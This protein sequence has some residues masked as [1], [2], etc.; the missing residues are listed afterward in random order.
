MDTLPLRFSSRSSYF[1]TDKIKFPEDI[2]LIEKTSVAANVAFYLKI[3]NACIQSA[4][5]LSDEEKS[6]IIINLIIELSR[7]TR[8]E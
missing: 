8:D 6:K 2:Q 3:K 4:S 5:S 1:V 7:R